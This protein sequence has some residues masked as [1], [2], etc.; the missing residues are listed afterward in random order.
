VSTKGL[1]WARETQHIFR[2]NLRSAAMCLL[3]KGAGDRDVIDYAEFRQRWPDPLKEDRLA[4][5]AR[6]FD[7][8][9]NSL[10][11]SPVFWVRLVGYAYVCRD[12][13]SRH[14]STIGITVPDLAV[15]SLLGAVQD[16][17]VKEHLQEY[18]A[19]FD[20]VLHAG[21]AE[22]DRPDERRRS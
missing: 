5:L 19:I 21:R 20:R 15:L 22:A 18:P 14:G 4:G 2:D 7:R 16:D 12:Y 10:A 17:Q 13:V 8:N 6:L 3:T 1:N 11:E 9:K